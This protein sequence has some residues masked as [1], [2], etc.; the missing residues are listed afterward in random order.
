MRRAGVALLAASL[1]A[2]S[3]LYLLQATSGQ[4]EILRL[5]RPVAQVIADSD[6]PAEL[7]RKLTLSRDALSFA[8]RV[9][10]LP[11]HGAYRHYADVGRPY[12]VWNVFAAPEFALELRSWCFPV[13]GCVG[14]R[15][16]F[17]ESDARG[18]A[19]DR[20]VAGEDVYVAGIAAYSTLGYFADPLLNTF[21]SFPDEELVGLIFHELAHQLVYVTDDSTFNESLASF[22]EQEGLRRWLAERGD[23][24]AAARLQLAGE[25]RNEVRRLLDTSRARLAAIFAAPIPAAEKRA[26][27]A[28]E[29][30]HLAAAYR[31]LRSGW[32]DPP[33]FDAWFATP[34]NN[35]TL[36]ALAAYDEF[37]PAFDAL[38]QR[39]AGSLL[40]FYARV[41]DLAKL[42]GPQRA[43]A[44]AAL[45]GVPRSSADLQ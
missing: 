14:Y 42:P 11:D 3:P 33:Y 5:R 6:T 13:A 43:E 36:G 34:L 1:G 35:A 23:A 40:A 20:A 8:H 10:L 30:A 32:G 26:A 27:K 7:R 21:V 41:R 24:A 28:A 44:L 12:V 29:F 19:D 25:R 16:Y 17:D 9:L 18:F 22:V 39:E 15:G 38:L 2:C 45:S 37:V 31:D 4:M